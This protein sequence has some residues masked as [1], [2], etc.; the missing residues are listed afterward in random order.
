[1]FVRAFQDH[2][3]PVDRGQIRAS[4][5]MDKKEAIVNI[6]GR[7]DGA[8]VSPELILHSFVA[9][10]Q[11]NLD[12]FEEME[13]VSEVIG[14]L[15][16]REIYIG[17][18]N[19]LPRNLFEIIFH[20]LDWPTYGFDYIGIAENVGRGRPHPDMIWEMLRR[21]FDRTFFVFENR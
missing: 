5:G 18:G 15:R 3:V 17:I 13:G 20:H 10:I 11:N 8:A 2:G 14:F 16:S 12:N 6:L 21:F 7:F 1:M 9:R 19:G 4:R